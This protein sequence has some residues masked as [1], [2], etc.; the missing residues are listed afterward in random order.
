MISLTIELAQAWMTS[1]S[2]QS[3][4]LIFNTLGGCLG[5]MLYRLYQ[6]MLNNMGKVE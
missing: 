1:R 5:A 6:Q 2:S 4:D 3:L